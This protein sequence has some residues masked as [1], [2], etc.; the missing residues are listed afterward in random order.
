MPVSSAMTVFLDDWRRHACLGPVD[1]HWSHLVA[2][3]E[4]ELRAFAAGPPVL[5]R[6]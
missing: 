6:Q 4:G 3:S 1:D 5:G 2:D